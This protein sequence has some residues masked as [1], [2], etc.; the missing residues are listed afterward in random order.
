MDLFVVYYEWFYLM[1][2]VNTYI[3]VYECECEFISK[4]NVCTKM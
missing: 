2:Q 3:Y 1:Q 4:A